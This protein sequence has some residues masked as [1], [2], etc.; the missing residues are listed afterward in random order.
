MGGADMVREGYKRESRAYDLSKTY[1]L[2]VVAEVPAQAE[3]VAA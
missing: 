3:E 1:V 2:T